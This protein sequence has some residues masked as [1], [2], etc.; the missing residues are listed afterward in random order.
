MIVLGI[1]TSC[2]ETAIAV[3]REGREILCSEIISQIAIHQPFGGVVPELA[4][5]EH[6]SH[7]LPLLQ[8]ALKQAHLSLSE[9]DLLAVTYGPGLM[10]ALLVGVNTAKALALATKKPLV[11]VNHVEAH[12]YAALMSTLTPP[13]F[14]CL[15]VILSGGHTALVLVEDLTQYFLIGQTIDDAIGEA[16]DKVAKM[17]GLGYPGGPIIERLAKQGNDTAYSFRAGSVKEQEFAFSFSGLKTAVLYS[18]SS[19]LTEAI[20]RDIAASFQRAAFQDVLKKT[21]RAAQKWG[22]SHL[23]FGGGVTNNCSLKTLFEQQAPHLICHWPTPHLSL[24][25]AAMV[26]GLGFHRYQLFGATDPLSLEPMARI[27]FQKFP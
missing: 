19:P 20:Q 15:G 2:D 21:T 5:Q 10:G 1:E 11:G 24:D 17:M 23:L 12:L 14:P 7:I 3:V 26:A 16:F 25:N 9:I 8:R 13:P 18:L 4:S 6:C 22:I 27:P